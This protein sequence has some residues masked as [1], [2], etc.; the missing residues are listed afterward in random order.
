MNRYRLTADRRRFL[1]VLEPLGCLV[2]VSL[3]AGI[4]A[5][6]GALWAN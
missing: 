2:F 3:C 1:A 4:G 5:A 6:I